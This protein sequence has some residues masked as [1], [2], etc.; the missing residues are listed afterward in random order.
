MSRGLTDTQIAGCFNRGLG[1]E[2][3]VRLIGGAEEP[4]YEPGSAG[5]YARIRYTRDYAASAQHELA[6][7]C[8]AGTARR[9]MSDY[10]Y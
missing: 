9:R 1:R 2:L 10:G 5:R 6:H 7:W 3:K 4:F 8:I